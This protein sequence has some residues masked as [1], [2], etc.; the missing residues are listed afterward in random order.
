MDVLAALEQ[1]PE[2][3]ARSAFVEFISSRGDDALWKPGGPEHLTASCFVF[4]DDL[5]QVP[6]THHKKGGYWVQFGGHLE[7]ADASL[8]DAARREGREE[9]GISDLQL[10]GDRV[11]DLDRHEL[12]GGFSCAAH[13]DVG[14]VA[15]AS[16]AAAVAV[17]SESLDVRWFEVEVLP[18][19]VPPGFAARLAAVR[20]RAT[21][22]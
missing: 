11:M 13:W 10:S 17:S 3:A 22:L 18:Q 4:S 2:G 1:A 12:H 9:S 19:A 7:A 8:S 21:G 6:L 14:F 16:P 20:A 15:V 5:R